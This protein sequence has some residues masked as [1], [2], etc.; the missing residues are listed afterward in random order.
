[1]SAPGEAKPQGP[2][3]RE[4]AEADKWTVTGAIAGGGRGN[5]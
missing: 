4:F 3:A 2:S 5:D 1:M